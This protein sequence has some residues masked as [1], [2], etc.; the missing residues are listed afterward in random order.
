MV[1][2]TYFCLGKKKNNTENKN[3]FWWNR[4]VICSLEQ[5]LGTAYCGMSTEMPIG[6]WILERV[7]ISLHSS[8]QETK[9][10]IHLQLRNLGVC[11]FVF[12]LTRYFTLTGPRQAKK[13]MCKMCGFTS[14][15]PCA[16][17]HP[18]ICS[19]FIHCVLSN[20]S[21]CRQWMPWS[22]CTDA[23]SDQ[24]LHCPHMPRHIFAWC[25]P[26]YISICLQYPHD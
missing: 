16:R 21:V 22:A 8:H 7:E 5:S 11:V 15:C 17:S 6:V 24:G 18:G 12:F 4:Q 14:S 25:S 23:Q 13:S 10:N 20:D 26:I 19:P 2:T 1:A 3:I 9:K